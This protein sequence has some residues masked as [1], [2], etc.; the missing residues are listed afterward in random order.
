[1]SPPRPAF[2][3]RAENLTKTFEISTHSASSL[4]EMILKGAF[5]RGERASHNALKGLSFSLEPG[6]SLAII[7]GNGSGKSTLLKLI[8]GISEPTSG[9]LEVNGT[10]AALLE[11]GAG[12]QPELTGMENIF[13]QGQILGMKRGEILGR[14]DDILD[15][16]DIG[17]FIHTPMKRYSSG[18]TVRLGFALAVFSEAE[19]LLVDEVLAVGDAA[20]QLKC[21]QKISDL[22]RRGKTILFVSH[23][24]EHIELAAEKALWIEAGEM[25]ALGTTDEVLERYLEAQVGG[26]QHVEGGEL[27]TDNEAMRVR[28]A[29]ILSSGRMGAARK[30]A[31]IEKLEALGPDGRARKHF[32]ADE[33]IT[34]RLTVRVNETL[35]YL[36]VSMAYSGQRGIRLGY[37]SSKLQGL[38]LRDL[39]PGLYEVALKIERFAALPGRYLLNAALSPENPFEFY[40]LHL[41]CQA[42]HIRGQAASGC[43]ALISAPGQWGPL[44]E[45]QSRTHG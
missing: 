20:F 18:M 31:S 9:S 39:K 35:P 29:T 2:A 41:R 34:F 38:P 28:S 10:V 14:L 37:N 16:A 32:E 4:K 3:L 43:G 1:M 5:M 26:G 8:S 22:K 12:F 21:L 44:T 40:D 15:F 36:S 25:R 45:G 27:E 30:P 19:V 11:L 13:L 17:P 24:P 6:Q 42:I 33:P 7:G 23:S